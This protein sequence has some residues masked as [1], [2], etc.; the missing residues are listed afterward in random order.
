MNLSKLTYEKQKR[1]IS[2]NNLK[3]NIEVFNYGLSNR[4]GDSIF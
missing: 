1:N 3:Q 4:S 2:L